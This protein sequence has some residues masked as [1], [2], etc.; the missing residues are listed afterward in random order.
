MC[1]PAW[2]ASVLSC[3][4]VAPDAW[5]AHRLLGR[6]AEIGSYDPCKLCSTFPSLLFQLK[7]LFRAQHQHRVLVKETPLTLVAGQIPIL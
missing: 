5:L 1:L 7:L 2:R 6:G 4:S 3:C